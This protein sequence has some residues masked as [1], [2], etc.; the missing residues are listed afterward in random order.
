[1]HNLSLVCRVT[2]TCIA[3]PA[4]LSSA[5]VSSPLLPSTHT[6]YTIN[7]STCTP[8]THTAP[9]RTLYYTIDIILQY[10]IYDYTTQYPPHVYTTHYSMAHYTHGT[11]HAW[12]TTRMAHYTCAHTLPTHSTHSH[13]LPTHILHTAHMQAVLLVVRRAIRAWRR[14]CLWI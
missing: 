6:H 14:L 2:W 1:M 4:K 13:T 5:K 3:V 8:R 9:T 7:T 11:L 10:S 12:H